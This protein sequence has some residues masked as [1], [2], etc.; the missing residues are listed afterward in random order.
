MPLYNYR[1]DDCDRE[2][3]DFARMSECDDPIKCEC[4]GQMY[5]LIGCGATSFAAKERYS[6]TMGVNPN[7]IAKA[8]KMYPGSEYTPDGRLIIKSRADKKR[9]MAQR[10]FVEYE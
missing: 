8:V 4:G 7:Q 9:K 5:V 3:E 6:S 10:G 1:C 2:E